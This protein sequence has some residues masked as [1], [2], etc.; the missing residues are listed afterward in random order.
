MHHILAAH[1]YEQDDRARGSVALAG[2][3]C[4]YDS[5]AGGRSRNGEPGGSGSVAAE[6]QTPTVNR[7][8]A[9]NRL[10]T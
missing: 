8:V 6:Q 1:Y 3:C 2:P 7:P 9:L 10:N 5:Q 4:D